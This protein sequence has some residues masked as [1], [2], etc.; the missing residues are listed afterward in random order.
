ML[1]DFWLDSHLYSPETLDF[2]WKSSSSSWWCKLIPDSNSCVERRRRAV[3]QRISEWTVL[4]EYS[5]S[6]MTMNERVIL[7]FSMINGFLIWMQDSTPRM[8]FHVLLFRFSCKTLPL[9]RHSQTIHS[10]FSSRLFIHDTQEPSDHHHCSWRCPHTF[11]SQKHWHTN[12]VAKKLSPSTVLETGNP[13]RGRRDCI[14]FFSTLIRGISNDESE[15]VLWRRGTLI[16]F[17]CSSFL[18]LILCHSILHAVVQLTL[19]NVPSLLE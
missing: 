7:S 10:D 4:M 11:V 16:T 8:L 14:S 15:G 12:V 1:R 19:S 17:L 13:R 3:T 5:L 2:E 18:S 9:H 6:K